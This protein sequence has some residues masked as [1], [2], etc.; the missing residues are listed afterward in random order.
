V[1]EGNPPIKRQKPSYQLN[2]NL[3]KGIKMKKVIGFLSLLVAIFLGLIDW[4]LAVGQKIEWDNA[5]RMFNFKV[6]RPQL[7]DKPLAAA[8]NVRDQSDIVIRS[9]GIWDWIKD[10]FS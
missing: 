4:Y 7:L 10:L 8:S 5:P 6:F 9:R 3:P 1:D 2:L